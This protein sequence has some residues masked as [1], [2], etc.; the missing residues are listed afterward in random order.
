MRVTVLRS[1]ALVQNVPDPLCQSGSRKGILDKLNTWVKTALVNDG[2][3]GVSGHKQNSELGPLS[4]QHVRQLP[5][6]LV[7]QDDIG[8]QQID[9]M[10]A[11][12]DLQRRLAAVCL[13]H[14]VIQVTQRV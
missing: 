13:K 12:N 3:A 14:H 11:I 2:V 8:E 5:T 6:V 7:G 4:K 9:M 10:S 1:I